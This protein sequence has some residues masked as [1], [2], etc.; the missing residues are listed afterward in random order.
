MSLVWFVAREYCKIAMTGEERRGEEITFE[1]RELLLQ[2]DE[3][4]IKVDED[5]QSQGDFLGAVVGQFADHQLDD[6]I[7]L[8]GALDREE[9]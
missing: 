8:S 7:E 4:I 3:Q 2:G 1:D 5:A 6:V 9:N